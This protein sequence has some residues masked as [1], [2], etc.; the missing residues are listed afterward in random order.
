MKPSLPSASQLN[1]LVYRTLG[2][3][4]RRDPS[5]LQSQDSLR[6]DLG[7]DSL[8]TIELVY[9][10]ED[11]FDLQIPDEDFGR[12]TTIGDVVTY[13][14]ERIQFSEHPNPRGVRNPPQKGS[15]NSPNQQKI[16]NRVKRSQS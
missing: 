16:T 1:Q 15:I 14:M 7:L 2:G 5:T 12:L 8:Q 10:V 6:D 13:L 4:L 11:A 3:Y 9:E